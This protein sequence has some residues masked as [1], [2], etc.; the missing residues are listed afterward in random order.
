MNLPIQGLSE[1]KVIHNLDLLELG[2]NPA[3]IWPDIIK[4][5][6]GRD[7]YRTND[8]DHNPETDTYE[9]NTELDFNQSVVQD[10]VWRAGNIHNDPRSGGL[11][12][13]ENKDD[14][15]KFARSVR[16]EER[17]GTP[18]H[19]N[20]QNPYTFEDGFW[21]GYVD[22]AENIDLVTGRLALMRDLQ[23]QGYDGIIIGEDTWNDTGD[24]NS[25][26]SKQYVVF[27]RNNVTPA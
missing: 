9:P 3:D 4:S 12:F 26:Y 17:Q 8:N 19:I 2:G 21:R 5:R 16:N 14:V 1:D 13:A 25:V 18:Y 23:T 6:D 11:W 20:L 7:E 27:D 22:A 15:E 10:V 24:E